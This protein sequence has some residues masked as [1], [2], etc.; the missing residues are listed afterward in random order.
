MLVQRNHINFQLL[1]FCETEIMKKKNYLKDEVSWY[2]Y[3]IVLPRN[4]HGKLFNIWNAIRREMHLRN[5]I[6]LAS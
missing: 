6:I 4:I 1:L 3:A 5:F 2:G